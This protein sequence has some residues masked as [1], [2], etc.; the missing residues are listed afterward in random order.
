MVTMN[1]QKEL[2]RLVEGM[3]GEKPTLLLHSCCAPCSSYCLLYLTQYFKVTV[4]YYNPNITEKDEYH[5]RVMEQIRLNE[6]LPTAEPVSFLE[7]SYEPIRFFEAAKGLEAEPEGGA[8][9]LNCYRLR[10]GEAARKTKELGF[11]YFTTSLTI[12]P[13][14]NAEQLNEI[15]KT[16]G[17]ANGVRWLPSDFKKNNGYKRSVELSAEYGLYRQNY[18]GCVFS[19]AAQAV[20]S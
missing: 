4:F 3:S 6:C 12:S 18:C 13:M 10:L 5:K 11:D 15:G 19:R 17:E 14:K 16:A 1:Y 2:D 9:C 8:R 20:K 7:G